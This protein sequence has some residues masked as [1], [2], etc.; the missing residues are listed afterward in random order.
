MV[1]HL[2]G[3][4]LKLAFP[5]GPFW[6][7]LLFL[8]YINDITSDLQSDSFLYADDTSLFEVVDDPTLT[9]V[10]LNNDLERF[11]AWTRD[12]LVTINSSKT[13]SIIFSV[14]RIK[15]S[16]PNIYFNNQIIENVSNHKHL[17][18]TLCSDLSWRAHIFNVYEKVSKKLNLLKG[19]KFKLSRETLSKLYKSLIR[20]Q[21]E[22]A[23][24]LWDG[25][26]VS[27]SDL[28]EHVQYQ[29]ARVVTGAM[30]GTSKSRL[31]EELAWEDLKTR[32]SIHKLVL[33]FK[34]VNNFTPNY[35]SNLLPQTV[36]QRSGLVLRHALNFTPSFRQQLCYGTVLIML[37]VVLYQLVSLNNILIAFLIFLITT[38]FWIIQLTDILLFYILVFVLIVVC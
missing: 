38:S 14:K 16:H 33:Y 10:N 17:G 6:A 21:M 28:L 3:C 13:K 19:L 5:R 37:N 4:K 25:C 36:Q 29:S 32:R 11:N 26:S 22:Y 8:I 35:L 12:C 20:P 15:P 24:I 34:I 1:S 27:E 2:T 30:Q 23:D 7:P 9:A 31:L 18:V